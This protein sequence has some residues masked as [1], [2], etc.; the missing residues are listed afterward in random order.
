M[1]PGSI[2]GGVTWDFF[3]GSF[4][5]NH[6]PWGRLSLWKWVPGISPGEKAAGAFGWRP[7][8]LVVPKVNKFQGL[9]LPRTPRA[10]SACRPDVGYLYFLY[11]KIQSVPRGKHNLL[12][13]F[14]GKQWNSHC[15]FWQPYKTQKYTVWEN[16]K[17]LNVTA[18]STQSYHL[19]LKS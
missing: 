16:V 15:L 2:P 6:V 17:F 8:T 9:N 13:L 7:T 11:L 18:Y 14:K 3:R 1:V 12:R 10:T 19:A 4:R 5:Q